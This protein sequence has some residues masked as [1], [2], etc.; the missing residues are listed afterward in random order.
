MILVK[1]VLSQC[2]CFKVK[3]KRKREHK[4]KSDTSRF[5]CFLHSRPLHISFVVCCLLVSFIVC[6]FRISVASPEDL[7]EVLHVVDFHNSASLAG[8]WL[9]PALDPVV[10]LCGGQRSILFLSLRLLGPLRCRRTSLWG[11]LKNRGWAL[12]HLKHAHRLDGDGFRG[13]EG[14]ALSQ[15]GG[16]VGII[17][18]IQVLVG[19]LVER[20]D[21]DV[22]RRL[23]LRSLWG[24]VDGGLRRLGWLSRLVELIESFS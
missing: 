19:T 23:V 14:R 8:L 17:G 9:A 18:L 5:Y 21:R 6:Q 1:F 10:G 16:R 20:V 12:D 15:R 7:T 24:L 13:D 22:E 3:F 11:F 2:G 4:K